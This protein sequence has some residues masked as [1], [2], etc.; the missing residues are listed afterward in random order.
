MAT[1]IVGGLFGITPQSYERQLSEQGLAQGEQ[2]GA[3]SPDAFG[4]SMLYAGGAQLGRGIGGA[5][6]AVDPQL[7]L[8]S[9]RNALAQQFDTSTVQGLAGLANALRERNDVAGATQ[10]AQALMTARQK[11]GELAAK[12]REH[13]STEQKNAIGLADAEFTRNSPEWNKKYSTELARLTAATSGGS[14][15]EIGVAEGTRE[16]VYFDVANRTQFVMKNDPSGKQV[17]VPFSGGV[18]RTTA[19]TTVTA[20]AESKGESAGAV[21]AAELDAARLRDAQVAAGKAVESAGI[22]NQLANTPQGV[23]G[24]GADFRVGALNVFSTLGL[25]SPRDKDALGNAQ[26]FNSLAGERVLSFIKQ[27]GTNPTD[28]DREFAKNI[29]PSLEKGTKT[30]Q[31]L[32]NYLTKRANETVQEASKMEQHFYSNAPNKPAYSLRGYQS[33]FLSNIQMPNAN[34]DRLNAINAAIAKKQAE[35]AK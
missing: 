27:L 11:E 7:Q 19:K 28:T 33:P 13:L 12:M 24:A 32:I 35:G 20:T 8:I 26:V 3:M 15:K 31:D 34:A 21:K 18:D 25:A 4:R 22:L 30:N 29:G 23:S 16:P 14:I 9:T 10:V 1:D 2:L 5:L 17:A 6:G